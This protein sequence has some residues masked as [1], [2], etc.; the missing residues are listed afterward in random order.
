[1]TQILKTNADDELVLTESK[2]AGP[3]M[4]APGATS[5]KPVFSISSLKITKPRT[6]EDIARAIA[7]GRV[8]E[9]KLD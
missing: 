4:P 2:P 5:G 6:A 7:Q 8:A 9:V 1:M 3:A